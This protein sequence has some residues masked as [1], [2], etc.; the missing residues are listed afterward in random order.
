MA[1]KDCDGRNQWSAE[2]RS[3]MVELAMLIRREKYGE[4][5]VPYEITWAEIEEVGHEIGRMTATV[6]DEQLYA[7]H[8]RHFHESQSCP[9]C[10]RV[11]S[12]GEKSRELKTRDGTAELEEPAFHCASCERSFFPSA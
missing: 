7:D 8:C 9:T 11:C 6:V 1:A 4:D 2:I 3:K 12:R 5:G 10:G